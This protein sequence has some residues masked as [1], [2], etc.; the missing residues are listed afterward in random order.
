MP[1]EGLFCRV[2]SP[3]KIEVDDHMEYIPKTFKA[4][5]ITLSDRAYR[6]EY[7][8]QSGPLIKQKLDQYIESG[9]KRY[10]IEHVIIPDDSVELSKLTKEA[11]NSGF[12]LFITTGGTGIGSRDV[13]P[14]T[15]IPFM[16]KE[17]PGIMEM[18]RVKYGRDNPNALLSRS[19]AGVSGK[20]QIY[21]LPGSKKAVLE[22][23]EVI[24]PTLKHSYY[25]V[26]D[27]DVHH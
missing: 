9:F 25:M 10:K 13:T 22:Y 6:G 16:D 23:L 8:D 17:L 24:L 15:L 27:L 14:E 2:I 11:K 1:K 4:L 3:G 5:V 12:D 26:N 18:I 7:K 20:M 21:A 19:V